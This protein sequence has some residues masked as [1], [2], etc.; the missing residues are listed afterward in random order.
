L[1]NIELHNYIRRSYPD[2]RGARHKLV[3]GVGVNDADYQTQPKGLICPAYMI[4]RS[5]LER[6]YGKSA[7][8][9]Y[10]T[11]VHV[12]VC[13]DWLIFSNFLNWWIL[14]YVEGWELDK[15]LLVYKSCEYSPHTCVYVPASVNNFTLFNKK[16]RGAYPVG[17][18]KA[19]TKYRAQCRN[20][21]VSGRAECLG[22]F[23]TA[24]QASMAW[25]KRKL[26]HADT[27]RSMFDAI[28]P[29]IYHNVVRAI[30][31]VT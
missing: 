6:C 13:N 11:Y 9:R 19:G 15:D 10:P 16:R 30:K 8:R 4:W 25:C 20:P 5:M 1:S 27:M 12:T 23:D 14:N 21:K 3:A 29:R 26:E 22:L 2:L 7:A 18:S 28:D 17:V 24:Q 31:E